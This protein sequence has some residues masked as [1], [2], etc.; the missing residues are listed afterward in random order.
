[1]PH[2]LHQ[3]LYVANALCAFLIVNL[4]VVALVQP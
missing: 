3:G 4:I 1:V 2:A